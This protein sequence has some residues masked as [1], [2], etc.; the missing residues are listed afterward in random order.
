LDNKAKVSVEE[1]R[2]EI[3]GLRTR[4]AELEKEKEGLGERVREKEQEMATITE[5]YQL[6][7]K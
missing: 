5:K 4:L 6:A 2:D 3:R 7:M 1:D